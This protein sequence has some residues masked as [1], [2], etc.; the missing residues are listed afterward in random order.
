[1]IDTDSENLPVC[2]NGESVAPITQEFRMHEEMPKRRQERES[3][4]E[5]V[6]ERGEKERGNE[7]TTERESESSKFTTV[8]RLLFSSEN[9]V[10]S[11]ITRA[12]CLYFTIN[13]PGGELFICFAKDKNTTDLTDFG[14]MKKRYETPVQCALREAYEESRKSF[15]E[16]KEEQVMNFI[17][18]YSTTSLIIFIPVISPDHRDIR[19]I[20]QEN[21][22]S[23][24]FL[25]E[26][27]KD[28]RCYNEISSIVWLGEEEMGNLLS[29]SPRHRLYNRSRRLLYSCSALSKDTEKMKSI[30]QNG[31]L[32]HENFELY[33]RQFAGTPTESEE[34]HMI[35]RRRS[36]FRF[37]KT[38]R[39]PASSPSFS[40]NPAL[41]LSPLDA[42]GD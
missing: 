40:L 2:K 29:D 41:A 23:K 7:R 6:N 17:A 35:P 12:G 36:T 15:G 39:A 4:T 1:M 31:L 8:S 42:F 18:L 19:K 38:R 21:F 33:E 9:S 16:I 11:S 10:V 13:E 20:I 25:T 28:K 24:H 27:E 30:L 3:A 5:R 14:G 34:M 26:E 22:E 32:I 37:K